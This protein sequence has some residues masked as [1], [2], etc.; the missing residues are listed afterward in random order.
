MAMT[1]GTTTGTQ[2]TA[3]KE[4]FAVGVLEV[5]MPSTGTAVAGAATL[6]QGAGFIT[7]ES[8]TTAAAA[9]YSLTLTN[10]FIDANTMIFATSALG[11][12]TTGTP[13]ATTTIDGAGTAT[14]NVQNIG[15]AAFNGTIVIGFFLV[16]KA[17]APL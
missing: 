17:G 2:R 12:S 16:R 3:R 11:T 10:S 6:N 1:V 9:T 8:L 4:A 15:A 7:S 13:E 5:S 14:I